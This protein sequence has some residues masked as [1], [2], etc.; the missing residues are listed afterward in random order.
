MST[1]AK[2]AVV[3]GLVLGALVAAW[4]FTMGLTGWYRDP[5]L[6]AAFFLVVPIE[7]A[8]LVVLLRRTA[9][10]NGFRAQLGLGSLASVVASPIVFAQSML[11]TTVAFPTYFAD[12]GDPGTPVSNAAT[13]AIATIVTG[14]IVSAITGAIVRK[15]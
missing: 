13:G 9:P 11:F 14:V 4:T 1:S 8:V 15:R 5:A 7:V 12:T 6:S 2:K 3:A 10:E